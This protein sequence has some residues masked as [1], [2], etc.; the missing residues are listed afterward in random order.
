MPVATDAS[1]DAGRDALATTDASEVDARRDDAG[2]DAGAT[3]ASALD[4]GPRRTAADWIRA[5]FADDP[6]L[7]GDLT[8]RNF[9]ETPVLVHDV[10]ACCAKYAFDLRAQED[11]DRREAGFVNVTITDL[12]SPDGFGAGIQTA[13]AVGAVIYLANVTVDPGWPLWVGYATTNYDGLVLDDAAA[14]YAED[15]TVRNWN[16]DGAMDDKATIS[17]FVRLTLEGRGHRGLRIWTPGPHYLVDSRLENEGGSLFWFRNC[18]TAEVRVYASTFDG[19]PTIDA[20]RYEC[21]DGTTPTF[22]YLDVDPRTT[23][24]M[25]EMFTP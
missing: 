6:E 24:E 20:S 13:N 22:V 8:R 23:G 16:A 15:L 18:D 21:D 10:T 12:E 19:E 11:P 9:V 25:H 3:D 4:A 14:V 7:T 5:H 17:Q 1:F 2:L